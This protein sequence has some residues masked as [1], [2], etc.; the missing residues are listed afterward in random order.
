MTCSFHVA[1]RVLAR[2][3]GGRD[4]AMIAA[5]PRWSSGLF[6]CFDDCS[7]LW[8]ALCCMPVAVG[9]LIDRLILPGKCGLITMLALFPAAVASLV[10]MCA[11]YNVERTF[12]S[13]DLADAYLLTHRAECIHVAHDRPDSA[14]EDSALWR[15]SLRCKTPKVMMLVDLLNYA[16]F[17][18]CAILI[19]QARFSLTPAI[20]PPITSLYVESHP[21][22]RHLGA[23]TN[24]LLAMYTQ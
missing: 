7:S 22:P 2:L 9:Q 1:T 15:S 3:Y 18:F 5:R 6:D 24:V 12:S 21:A 14:H 13:V 16:T 19:I 8:T 11:P 4:A 17:L 20:P 23:P 10:L